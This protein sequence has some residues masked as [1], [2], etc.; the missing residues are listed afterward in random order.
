MLGAAERVDPRAVLAGYL[1]TGDDPA[2]P[3]RRV[4][5]GEMADLCLLSVPLDEALRRP[6]AQFV[7]LTW[8]GGEKQFPQ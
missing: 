2:G 3:P 4:R 1:S 8:C 5:P 7:A 6:S